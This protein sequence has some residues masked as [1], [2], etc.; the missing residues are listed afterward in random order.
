M[1]KLMAGRV[2]LLVFPE[3][4]SKVSCLGK[5]KRKDSSLRI[6]HCWELGLPW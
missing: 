1:K 4:K 3:P 2:L 6:G 5:Q